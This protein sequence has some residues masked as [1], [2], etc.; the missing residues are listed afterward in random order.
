MSFRVWQVDPAHLT[1]YYDAALCAALVEAGCEVSLITSP[2]LYD[3]ASPLL[4]VKQSRTGYIQKNDY[5]RGIAYPALLRYPRMRKILRLSL[6]PNGHLRMLREAQINAPHIVHFQWFRVPLLD[7]VLVQRL[8]KSGI[9]VIATAHDVDPL[10]EYA[11]KRALEHLYKSVDKVVVHAV[12]NREAF[13]ARYPRIAAERVAVVP[14]IA[15]NPVISTGA[16]RELARKQLGIPHNAPAILFFG[17]IKAYKGLD[18]LIE[19]VDVVRQTFPELWVIVAGRPDD[20]EQAALMQR[21]PHQTIFHSEYIPSNVMW[22]YHLAAD[23]AVFPYRKITQSGALITAMAYGLPVIVTDV[24]AFPE[25][26]D[27]NGWIIPPD[28]SYALAQV[29][30]KALSDRPLLRLMG[31]RSLALLRE[32]HESSKVAQQLVKLYGEILSATHPL[33]DR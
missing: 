2:F 24:G 33:P 6:Y 13:L 3:V 7:I 21:C 26:I 4:N 15:L 1:P 12:T 19:A 29:L 10:F 31:E 32:N 25:T 30:L 14:H 5:F 18:I 22:R 23:L 20:R 17:S 28:D 9:P 27:H 11:G 16:N 8:R